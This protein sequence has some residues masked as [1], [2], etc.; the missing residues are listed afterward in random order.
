[1]E[2][3]SQDKLKKLVDYDPIIGIFTSKVI[4]GKLNPGDTVGYINNLGYRIIMIDHHNYRASRLAW[5]Y[6]YGVL[7]EVIDHIKHWEKSND[8]INNLRLSS[9]QKN[10]L[11]MPK[12][13]DNTSGV[14]GVTWDSF[15]NKWKVT[16][17]N[18]YKNISKRF[19]DFNEACSY[20]KS[21]EIQLGYSEHHGRD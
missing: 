6:V 18:N 21:L 1:M 20:R 19:K 2:K 14:V 5:L 12:R 3:I 11:N 4:R 15:R 17:S 16:I 10:S 8:A 7:P 13:C 9:Y